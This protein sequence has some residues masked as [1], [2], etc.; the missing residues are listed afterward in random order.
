MK[1][2]F[3]EAAA[4]V[5]TKVRLPRMEFCE[6]CNGTGAKAG[7]GV[8]ACV[9][10]AG[11]GQVH[12]QQGFFSILLKEQRTDRVLVMNPSNRL[13]QERGYGQYFDFR[14]CG[15]LALQGNGVGNHQLIHRGIHDPFHSR[16]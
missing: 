14:T 6:S 16:P 2:S 7:T 10:C 13:S 11:R 4:G 9:T 12:Y 15:G 5:N 1:L 8:V 3:E